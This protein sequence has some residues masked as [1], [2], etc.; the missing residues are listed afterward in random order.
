[1]FL[2]DH[3]KVMNSSDLAELIELAESQLLQMPLGKIEA[4]PLAKDPRMLEFSFA[5]PGP[6][7]YPNETT[8]EEVYSSENLALIK[9]QALK[10]YVHLPFC[11]Q[12]CK[13]CFYETSIGV[14]KEEIDRYLD[15]AAPSSLNA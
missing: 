11:A 8:L 12:R 5:Y 1:M 14:G 13:F 10:L 2:G 7:P 15:T 4:S 6:L 9:D 3:L